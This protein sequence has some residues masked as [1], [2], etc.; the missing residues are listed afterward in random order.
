M[1]VFWVKSLLDKALMSTQHKRGTGERG[2]RGL[3]I[4][5]SDKA[6]LNPSGELNKELSFPFNEVKGVTQ[7]ER[8][9][10]QAGHLTQVMF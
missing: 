7:C 5:T 2:K 10:T 9:Q 8:Q 6:L 3:L 4:K 1:S